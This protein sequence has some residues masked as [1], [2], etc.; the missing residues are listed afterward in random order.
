[1]SGSFE[2]AAAAA[3]RGV[4]VWRFTGRTEGDLSSA[5][6]GVEARRRAVV[7]LPWTWLRQVHGSEV[8]VVERPGEHAGR[9]ADAAVTAVPGAAVA[10]QAADC[11]PVV[12]LGSGV[13]G[14]VHA[15]WRGLV[16]GVLV[17]AVDVMRRLGAGTVQAVVGPCIR[18]SC[19]EFG[20]DDLEVAATVLGGGVRACTAGGRPALD[21]PGA[22]RRSLAGAGV[23]DV[24]DQGVCTA[25]STQHWSHRARA[26]RER[27][28]AVAWLE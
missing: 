10:V 4:P 21:L 23:H 5:A 9:A 7:D 19:Y 22:V 28:A 13:V 26:D 27:Q 25:C 20:G 12:L 8:V 3:H 16:A 18:P 24:A 2:G 14:V 6:Q 15:G 1:M 17:A 11:A